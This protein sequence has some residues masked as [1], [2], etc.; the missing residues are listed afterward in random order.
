MA[1]TRYYA[2]MLA[3]LQQRPDIAARE[4][5]AALA[6]DPRHARAANIL[7]AS[8]ASLRQRDQARAAF[9]RALVL[10]PR[11]PA[12][13]ANLATLEQEVGN[14]D[15]ARRLYVEALTIDPANEGARQGLAALLSTQP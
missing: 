5:S 6:A 10:D 7:G 4:A 15:E 9:V 8:L 1:D 14:H 13:Y 2:A 11:A 12:T 3:Y